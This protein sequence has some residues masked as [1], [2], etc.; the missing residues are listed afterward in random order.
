[1]DVFHQEF[2]G[3]R[4]TLQYC[5]I[6][7]LLNV[8]MVFLVSWMFFF[9]HFQIFENKYSYYSVQCMFNDCWLNLPNQGFFL[10]YIGGRTIDT[11]DHL[12]KILQKRI[13]IVGSTLRA[14]SIQVR[15]PISYSVYNH[16][17]FTFNTCKTTGQYSWG[18]GYL[19]V[20]TFIKCLPL[21]HVKL[22]I[23]TGEC[24]DIL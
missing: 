23:N 24:T 20:W 13:T 11:G 2:S 21:I 1:M 15:G 19:I 7:Y 3:C 4:I 5:L 9:Q 22:P 10:I 6:K 17:V 16:I 12:G 14:R 8:I 18:D